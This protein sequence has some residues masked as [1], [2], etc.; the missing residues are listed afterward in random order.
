MNTK[1][2]KISNASES[3]YPS[4][5]TNRGQGKGLE[6]IPYEAEG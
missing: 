5:G 3:A 6:F 1:N 4:Q 2:V